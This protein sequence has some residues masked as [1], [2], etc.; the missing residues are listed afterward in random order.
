MGRICVELDSVDIA[1]VEGFALSFLVPEPGHQYRKS[2]DLAAQEIF[3]GDIHVSDY[4]DS[5]RVRV[6]ALG[7]IAFVVAPPV[8]VTP[9]FH[10]LPFST[11][12]IL[13]APVP[14]SDLQL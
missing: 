12:E 1:V 6:E 11:L 2:I 13:Y 7:K 10:E 3:P 9:E 4:G 5:D 14:G 8:L